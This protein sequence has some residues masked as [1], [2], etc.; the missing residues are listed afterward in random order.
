MDGGA[1]NKSQA[2]SSSI[3]VDKPVVGLKARPRPG[4][5]QYVYQTPPRQ[6][7][8]QRNPCTVGLKTV[9]KAINNRSPE[10]REAREFFNGKGKTGKRCEDIVGMKSS[11]WLCGGAFKPGDLYYSAQCDHILPVAQG[12]IFLDLYTERTKNPTNAAKIEYEWSHAICN[13][14][15]NNNV[16]IKGNEL[17][18]E[19]D[20]DKIVK[21]LEYLRDKH[22]VPISSIEDQV[23][24]I[25]ARLLDITNYINQ[26]PN[27]EINLPGASCPIPIEFKPRGGKTFKRKSNEFSKSSRSKGSSRSNVTTSRSSGK[28]RTSNRKRSSK[29]S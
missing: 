5:Q 13:N 22:S 14:V 8:V 25:Q 17:K 15:K 19:P 2:R 27:Y 6:I 1:P 28:R 18:F 29:R 26:T 10:A 21:L 23:A 7:I 12:A 11:C 9:F 3:S 4:S 16:L 20:V 24:R